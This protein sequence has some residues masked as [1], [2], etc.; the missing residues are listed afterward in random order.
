L[1]HRG[2]LQAEAYAR[3][4]SLATLF[5][6][7]IIALMAASFQAA[8]IKDD[9]YPVGPFVKPNKTLLKHNC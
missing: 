9:L 7:L 6:W 8:W 5:T 4:L 3:G 2:N 1:R